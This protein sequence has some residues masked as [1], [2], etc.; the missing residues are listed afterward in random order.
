MV[1]LIWLLHQLNINALIMNCNSTDVITCSSDRSPMI[2]PMQKGTGRNVVWWCDSSQDAQTNVQTRLTVRP[3]PFG[4]YAALFGEE[5]A[6]KKLCIIMKEHLSIGFN[7]NNPPDF[8]VFSHWRNVKYPSIFL[9]IMH[10]ACRL[11]SSQ[12]YAA[13]S[14]ITDLFPV[15]FPRIAAYSK[16]VHE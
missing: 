5:Q 11:L 1:E 3:H 2:K 9:Y 16:R 13:Y 7:C 14:H 12:C 4:Y 15:C 8:K 10:P 6:F